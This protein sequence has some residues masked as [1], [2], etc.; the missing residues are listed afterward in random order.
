MKFMICFLTGAFTVM[1]LTMHS[2]S[3]VEL[4]NEEIDNLV[5]RSYQYVAMYNAINKGRYS[6]HAQD[7]GRRE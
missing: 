7:R 6:K 5:Q 3:A 4:S 2:A 1:P